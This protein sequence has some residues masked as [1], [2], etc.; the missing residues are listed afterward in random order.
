MRFARCDHIRKLLLLGACAL[1]GRLASA[2]MWRIVYEDPAPDVNADHAAGPDASAAS[3]ASAPTAIDSYQSSHATV[4]SFI[5]ADP[6]TDIDTFLPEFG[7][8]YATASPE[9]AARIEALPGVQSVTP[10]Q[11]VQ[12]LH[13]DEHFK[14]GDVIEPG[15]SGGGGGGGGGGGRQRRCRRFAHVGAFSPF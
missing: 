14:S 8:A 11:Q 12:Y 13:P 1:C 10:V 6:L 9:A 2:D 4:A 15:S 3:A 7:L 5:A